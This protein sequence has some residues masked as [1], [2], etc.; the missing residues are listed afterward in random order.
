MKTAFALA[1][2]AGS[3]LSFPIMDDPETANTARELFERYKETV[4]RD[5][6]NDPLGLSKAQTNCG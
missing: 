1:A 5:L 3:A 6:S 4:S 2:V